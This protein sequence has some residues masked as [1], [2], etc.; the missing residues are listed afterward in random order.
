MK[1]PSP[2]H[3]GAGFAI[4]FAFCALIGLAMLGLIAWA[5]VTLVTHFA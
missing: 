3:A 5:I 4:W 2:G 1:T